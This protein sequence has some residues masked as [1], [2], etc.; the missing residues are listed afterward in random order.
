MPP[1]GALPA[2]SRLAPPRPRPAPLA[3]LLAAALRHGGG[4]LAVAPLCVWWAIWRGGLDTTLVV[5]GLLWLAACAILL[6]T[7]V[8]PARPPRPALLAWSGLVALAGL[9]LLSVA[10]ADDR[11]SA[12]DGALRMALTAG[13]FGLVVLWPPTVRALGALIAAAPVVALAGLVSG[14]LGAIG[15]PFELIDGRLS[16][17]TGYPNATAVLALI[18]AVIA[19]VVSADATRRLPLR[20]FS[21]GL[22]AALLGGAVLPQS[23]SVLLLGVPIAILIVALAPSRGRAGVSGLAAVVIVLPVAPLLLDVRRAALAGEPNAATEGLVGLVLLLTLGIAAGVVLGWAERRGIGRE[24]GDR[25]AA[26]WRRRASAVRA[27]FRAGAVGGRA[28]RRYSPV[29]SRC[30]WPR[31]ASPWRTGT[32]PTSATRT[33][34]RSRTRER[35]SAPASAPTGP[36]TGGSR[37]T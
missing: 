15:D 18:G 14:L 17:P 13:A 31:P 7:T 12:I 34:P 19:V 33:T 11:G 36:T 22:A 10:W 24:R 2:A 26:D 16:A 23:R 1:D 30:C 28:G 8:R 9:S 3:A 21:L 35:A 37:P 4:I 25:F 29:A 27:G 5:P 32:C 6:R 20:A